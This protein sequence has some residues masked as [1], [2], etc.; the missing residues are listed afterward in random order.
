MSSTHITT[1]KRIGLIVTLAATIGAIWYLES[2]S[3]H[4]VVQSGNGAGQ[5]INITAFSV[6]ASGT[7]TAS[8]AASVAQ[9]IAAIAIHDHVGEGDYDTTE[10]FIQKA[11]AER[12]L[13][14]GMGAVAV[15][16]STVNIAPTNLSGVGSPETYF[17]AARNEYL[18]NGAQG[19]AGTQTLAALQT[20]TPGL[21][22]LYL[23][24]T[25][26]FTDQYATNVSAGAKVIFRYDSA[27]VYFVAS[28]PAGAT[29]RV[30][31][32]GAPVT[33]AASGSDVNDGILTVGAS[34]LYGVIANP[35]GAGEH[36]LEL[37]IDSPGLQAFTFTFG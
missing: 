31:Q 36:T 3:A 20:T 9:A 26:D 2:L 14:L 24:G 7:S 15:P 17:G 35:D 25:W 37:I 12:A 16:T 23:A 5:N 11:L 29:V 27:K 19:V 13:A 1:A 8:G 30:Y 4:P 34:R 21:N 18:A 33:V 6:T 32:D 10:S 28:A 22:Q